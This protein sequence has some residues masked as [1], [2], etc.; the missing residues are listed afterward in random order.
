M[1]LNPGSAQF[2]WLI[3]LERQQGRHV[4][5]A[6]SEPGVDWLRLFKR[7]GAPKGPNSSVTPFNFS[8]KNAMV[9]RSVFGWLLEIH[10]GSKDDTYTDLVFYLQRLFLATAGPNIVAMLIS[11]ILSMV[12]EKTGGGIQLI[13]WVQQHIS[14]SGTDPDTSHALWALVYCIA[15]K[16]TILSMHIPQLLQSISLELALK[17]NTE[18]RSMV[19]M[20]LEQLILQIQQP[21]LISGFDIVKLLKTAYLGH[22]LVRDQIVQCFLT[23]SSRFLQ[24]IAITDFEFFIDQAVQSDAPLS[25][26]DVSC[27]H[28]SKLVAGLCYQHTMVQAYEAHKQNNRNSM[29]GKGTVQLDL[30]VH[31]QHVKRTIQFLLSRFMKIAVPTCRTVIFHY[32]ERMGDLWLR[33]NT[34]HLLEIFSASK[35][36]YPMP[37]LFYLLYSNEAEQIQLLDVLLTFLLENP[38]QEFYLQM[39]D[40][41]V[42]SMGCIGKILSG[43]I[44]GSCMHWI[45]KMVDPVARGHVESIMICLMTM[46]APPI[47]FNQGIVFLLDVLTTASTGAEMPLNILFG[48]ITRGSTS[49]ISSKLVLDMWGVWCSI[50]RPNS[51]FVQNHW[52]LLLAILPHLSPMLRSAQREEILMKWEDSLNSDS[53]SPS[54]V[55]C[56]LTLKD[57]NTYF[58][59]R[60]LET[61]NSLY[62]RHLEAGYSHSKEVARGHWTAAQRNLASW[63]KLNQAYNSDFSALVLEDLRALVFMTAT[64][65]ESTAGTSPW[66]KDLVSAIKSIKGSESGC[67]L[68]FML[69]E[70]SKNPI[71]LGLLSKIIADSEHRDT[72][73]DPELFAHSWLILRHSSSISAGFSFLWS[74]IHSEVLM[75]DLLCHWTITFMQSISEMSN[76]W[77]PD[78]FEYLFTKAPDGVRYVFL[79]LLL[80]YH[81]WTMRKVAL[82]LCHCFLSSCCWSHYGCSILTIIA[83]IVIALS[84]NST[85][86]AAVVARLICETLEETFIRW[87]LSFCYPPLLWQSAASICTCP[88]QRDAV[89]ALTHLEQDRLLSELVNDQM[90]QLSSECH[91]SSCRSTASFL[92]NQDQISLPCHEPPSLA[93]CIGIISRA[94]EMSIL[95]AISKVFS[96]PWQIL[97][98]DV[99]PRCTLP[100]YTYLQDSPVR[101]DILFSLHDRHVL[102]GLVSHEISMLLQDDEAAI[103]LLI[104]ILH[105]TPTI[106]KSH[107]LDDNIR[108]LHLNEDIG[109]DEEL[110]LNR[111]PVPQ[112]KEKIIK[113]LSSST[114]FWCMDRLLERLWNWVD[115]AALPSWFPRIIQLLP[116]GVGTEV[117]WTQELASCLESRRFCV[118]LL[119]WILDYLVRY[120]SKDCLYMYQT[121]LEV[122]LRTFI[123]YKE[124]WPQVQEKAILLLVPWFNLTKEDWV[125]SRIYKAI[126]KRIEDAD[127]PWLLLLVT[128]DAELLSGSFLDLWPKVLECAWV[129]SSCDKLV[130]MV[131]CSKNS[132]QSLIEWVSL[133]RD[134]FPISMGNSRTKWLFRCTHSCLVYLSLKIMDEKGNNLVASETNIWA[135]GI[136]IKLLVLEPASDDIIAAS[137]EYLHVAMKLP[138]VEKLM[139]AL[140]LYLITLRKENKIPFHKIM[141]SIC[142]DWLQNVK[143][144]KKLSG[145]WVDRMIAFKEAFITD[146]DI[147]RYLQLGNSSLERDLVMPLLG[148][149]YYLLQQESDSETHV[150]VVEH[151]CDF[152]HNIMQDH[153]SY[154][155]EAALEQL[156]CIYDT[157]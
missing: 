146:N 119:E 71:W 156:R 45:K 76:P 32:F 75:A 24:K 50:S 108:S 141:A 8:S 106:E 36:T 37:E 111:S 145:S 31:I 116:C 94:K 10:K 46:H 121:S 95:G 97:P 42:H 91:H 30:N 57:L 25:V 54:A 157:L 80:Q 56:I 102:P 65:V 105:P 120:G 92:V 74:R 137:L 123:Q 11:R 9:L 21:S 84:Y 29:T 90:Q 69:R 28:W 103:P 134:P 26:Q 152:M 44:L 62:K 83:S 51:P 55:S 81:P 70:A 133:P 79:D 35:D 6:V 48:A 129:H 14:K 33:E 64:I 125:N 114:I 148:V 61:I 3:E 77:N 4:D 1:L 49:H 110:R 68:I 126:S 99:E 85:E 13:P 43:R 5:T 147:V 155:S 93:S 151:F 18:S 53:I 150:M 124:E 153:I 23:F 15:L 72:S 73:S 149:Y 2:K 66:S 122:V 136:A 112:K 113:L 96:D 135:I 16:S 117:L 128:V 39:V 20:A 132:S 115:T 118:L 34:R 139:D 98:L 144:P 59:D 12:P 127:Y 78:L 140:F 17:R 63:I 143:T 104:S 40:H 86:E 38:D 88:I 52:P 107:R 27:R 101:L 131:D 67:P 60:W 58:I 130:T 47:V 87:I 19:V 89:D 154:L 142:L 82:Y 138:D 22:R 7:T 41:L 109:D 100:F